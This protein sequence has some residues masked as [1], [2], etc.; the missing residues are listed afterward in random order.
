MKKP[1]MII[2]DYGHT[3][4]YEPV[5]DCASG[6]R[7]VLSLCAVNPRQVTAEELSEQYATALARLTESSRA[8]E[9]DFMD[10]AVKR[11]IYDTLGLRFS[12][13][14][15]KL[16]R[17]FWDAAGPGTPMPGI[18]D[19]LSELKRR[20]IRTGVLSNMNFRE[21]NV[22]SRI[23]RL[24][25]ENAFEFVLCSCEYATRKPREDFFR[26]AL[27]K[28]GLQASQVWYC[29]D[30]PRCDVLGAY[31]SGICPVWYDNENG[32]PYQSER[33]RVSIGIPCLRIREW[34]ELIDA[35]DAAEPE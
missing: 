27:A 4:V 11:M 1:D 13:E 21:E 24:L 30:N 29:V 15:L 5:F 8:A 14:P 33:D 16:E 9:C 12:A 22:H 28:A 2:F 10:M 34:N 19:L 35:L 3:L 17:C 25:P 31:A 7:A 6:F 26:L 20:G 32:S 18:H 23:D